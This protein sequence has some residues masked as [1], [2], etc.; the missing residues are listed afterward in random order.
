V[1]AISVVVSF[2]AIELP[3]QIALVPQQ[4]LIEVF[5]PDGPDQP[6]NERMRK[7]CARNGLD[8]INLEDPKVREPSLKTKQWIVIRGK[9]FGHAP[10]RDRPVKHP[11]HIG[12]VE[13]GGADAK[14]DNPASENVHHHYDPV[15]PERN[16]LTPEEVDAPQAVPGLPENRE[17]GGAIAA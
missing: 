2:V 8:L 17:P 5:A 15:A 7:G 6:L 11:A 4:S 12:T 10:S 16:R 9:M 14:S 1:A 3:L 13:I